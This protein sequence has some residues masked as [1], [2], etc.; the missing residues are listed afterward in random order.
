MVEYIGWYSWEEFAEWF[1]LLPTF[2]QILMVIGIV[3][4]VALVITAVYYLLKGI[5]YLI[6]YICK[7]IGYLFYY[8]GKGIYLLFEG[9]YY[10]ISGKQKPSSTTKSPKQHTEK[11]ELME[12][13]KPK[14]HEPNREDLAAPKIEELPQFCPSCGAPMSENMKNALNSAGKS[15]CEFCGAR[16]SIQ[17]SKA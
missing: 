7:G 10:A 11:T 2:G 14:T 4:I 1:W 16:F 9:L 15:F 5:S 3:A 8:M 13:Q 17:G 12:S 6:Y